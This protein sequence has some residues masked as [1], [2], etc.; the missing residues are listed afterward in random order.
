MFE[1][2]KKG[3]NRYFKPKARTELYEKRIHGLKKCLHRNS[4]KDIIKLLK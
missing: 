4:R 3:R 2:I 1:E